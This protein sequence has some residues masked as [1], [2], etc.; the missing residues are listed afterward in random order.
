M[1]MSLDDL[2][3][4]EA[5]GGSKGR[6]EQITWLPGAGAA[7]AR[8]HG[9]LR[10]RSRGRAARRVHRPLP[11]AFADEEPRVVDTDD[12]GEAWVWQGQQLPN[13]GFNAVVGRPSSEYGFE[14]TRFDEMRRGAWDVN[15]RVADMD[16]DGVWASL[17][18]P[19]FLPGFVG[20]RL[21]MWPD[22]DELALV[23]MRAYNDWHLE[24][25]CGAHPERFVPNQ[26]AYL[27][28]PE[29]AARGDPAQ[30]GARLQGGDVLGGARQARA[31]DDPL[32]L[33]GSAVRGVRRDRHRAVPARRFVGHVAHHVGRRAARDPR[34]AVR[35]VRDVQRG[36]LALLEGAGALPRHPHL[37]VRRRHRLGRRHP[38]PPRPLLPLPARLPAD[39]ARRRRSRRARCCAA[40]SGSARSTTTRACSC[41]TASASTTSSWSPTTRTPTRRGPTRRRCSSA[42]SATRACPTHDARRITWRER[43]GAVPAPGS[44]RVAAVTDT[45][46]AL[47]ARERARAPRRR[48]VRRGGV[49]RGDDVARV[50]RALVADG[51]RRSRHAYAPGD[52]VALQL[53]DGPGV[54]TAMLACEKAGIVAVGIG[55]RAGA[56]EVAHLVE[57]TGA[58]SAR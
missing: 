22:S 9:D 53:P 34:G 46:A 25:W 44:R 48:R 2:A 57:R 41:A 36:R 51:R 26:I 47:V 50:R 33:L 6:R 10:R 11:E 54:H 52:R 37:P 39:V 16:I 43:V 32:R 58:R 28:D 21:T 4:S 24:A 8:V 1:N 27:R 35:R 13:V 55:A 20:Q 42:S 15:A 31:A 14:P 5:F 3:S 17:C 38:R 23:A 45:I 49:G 7:R 40:T 18:F 19:S 12:G 29:I 30:R 56:R